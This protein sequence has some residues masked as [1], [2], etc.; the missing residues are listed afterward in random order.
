MIPKVS[1]ITAAW[2]RPWGLLGALRSA[3]AQT[4]REHEHIVVG[5]GCPEAE[6][7]VKAAGDDRTVYVGLPERVGDWGVTPLLEGLKVARAPWI[8]VLADDNVWRPRFLERLYAVAEKNRDAAFIY[9][10]REVRAKNGDLKD[11]PQYYDEDRPRWNGIDLGEAIYSRAALDRFGPWR[12]E[13]DKCYDW[14]WFE[15]VMEAG[16][17]WIHVPDCF[18]FIF[19]EDHLRARLGGR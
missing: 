8:A 18:E 6:R 3:Q 19:Y 16:G 9:G 10:C 13:G 1:I 7:V 5:D 14:Q 2:M 17:K 4:L 11:H 12:W 15:R